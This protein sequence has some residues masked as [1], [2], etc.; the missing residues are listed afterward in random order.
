MSWTLHCPWCRYHIIVSDRG[1]RGRD[2]GAG[3]EAADVMTEHVRDEH[4]RTW[5]QFLEA[6]KRQMGG[7]AS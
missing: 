3:V 6:L 4:D 5:R 2:M 7:A 1:M